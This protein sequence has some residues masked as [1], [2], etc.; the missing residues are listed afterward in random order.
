[1]K[2]FSAIVL[3]F[4]MVLSLA[5]C[6]GGAGG[7]EDITKAEQGAITE[8]LLDSDY[9]NLFYA[10]GES[11]DPTGLRVMAHYED[12]SKKRIET[13]ATISSDPITVSDRTV[14]I[15]YEGVSTTLQV[16]P[17]VKFGPYEWV[18]LDTDG[19]KYLL[20]SKYALDKVTPSADKAGS[21]TWADSP[22]RTFL[23]GEF[24]SRFAA[25]EQA[26]IQT[27]HVTAEDNPEYKT[28]FGNETDDKVFCLSFEEA[29]KYFET[30]HARS[31]VTLEDNDVHAD[32]FLRTPG[33]NLSFVGSVY[34]F[35]RLDYYGNRV[36]LNIAVRPA[37]WVKMK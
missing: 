30:E 35:G 22:V 2:K 32:W 14:E 1:M 33:K 37:M 27:T 6:S 3:T 12:G 23:N 4:A 15:S 5:A 28:E 17:V 29:D 8:I 25:D 19:D 16:Y 10:E 18:V 9:T 34:D 13:L 11:F 21:V 36:D 24:L 20:L 7:N 31:A 26:K